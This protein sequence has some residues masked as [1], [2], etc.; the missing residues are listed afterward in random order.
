MAR[1]HLDTLKTRFILLIVALGFL[2]L[3]EVLHE[4][5]R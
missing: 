3:V 1:I 4:L 2:G 5:I